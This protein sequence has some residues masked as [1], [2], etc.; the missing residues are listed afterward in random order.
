[1]DYKFNIENKSVEG[2]IQGQKVFERVFEKGTYIFNK[3]GDII[4]KLIF[5]GDEL[6]GEIKKKTN[7]FFNKHGIDSELVSKLFRENSEYLPIGENILKSN[8]IKIM[9][10]HKEEEEA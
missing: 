7:L 4:D 1:M 6:V 3:N 9:R 10:F 8:I 5:S 2:F